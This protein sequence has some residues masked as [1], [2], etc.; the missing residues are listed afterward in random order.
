MQ[1]MYL[2]RN[3]KVFVCRFTTCCCVPIG[4]LKI[5]D[6]FEIVKQKIGRIEVNA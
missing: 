6:V 5:T 1:I 3:T 4:V 2:F